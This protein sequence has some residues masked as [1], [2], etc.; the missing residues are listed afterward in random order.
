MRAGRALV[1]ALGA[2]A[3]AVSL[4][5]QGAAP[6]APKND[7]KWSDLKAAQQRILAPLKED[8]PTFDA[9]RKRKW[10]G[11][12]NRYPQMK[13][14]EQARLQRRMKAWAALTPEER[15]AARDNFQIVRELPS[16]QKQQIRQKWQ[17]YQGLP[18]E[19]RR[20]LAARPAKPAA[21]V[22]PPAAPEDAPRAA[23]TPTAPVVLPPMDPGQQ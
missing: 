13:P 16:D 5:V 11:V 18:E 2:L 23:D 10:I 21:P 15:R 14:E 22:P 6:A 4:Q 19:Q 8:W 9:Q 12:A 3:L 17:E 7:P 1:A 20:A